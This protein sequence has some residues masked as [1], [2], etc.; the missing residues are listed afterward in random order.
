MCVAP[1]W[2]VVYARIA[3]QWYLF[4]TKSRLCPLTS[5]LFV[6]CPTLSKACVLSVS[7]FVCLCG[8]LFCSSLRLNSQSSRDKMPAP[9]LAPRLS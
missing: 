8:C 4:M 2:L 5:C 1:D 9:R 3:F 7:L 6:S